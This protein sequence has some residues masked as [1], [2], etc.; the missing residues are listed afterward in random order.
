MRS[1]AALTAIALL[2]APALAQQEP[3]PAK[4]LT[5]W[6]MMQI[7][8]EYPAAAVQC[9]KDLLVAIEKSP[10]DYLF[11]SDYQK[12]QL[13][14]MTYASLKDGTIPMFI[15]TPDGLAADPESAM[16]AIFSGGMGLPF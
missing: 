8:V 5:P 13:W 10:H 3:I 16:R 2:C 7:E 6:M 14:L 4:R 9:L 15:C 11:T 12:G 1:I